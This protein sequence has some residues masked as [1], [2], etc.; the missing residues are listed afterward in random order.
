MF[1]IQQRMAGLSPA[2]AQSATAIAQALEA[3]RLDQAERDVTAARTAAPKHPEILRLFGLVEKLRGRPQQAIEALTQA[4]TLQP[5]DPFIQH[6]LAGAYEMVHDHARALA[7]MRRLCDLA[8]EMAASWFILG[9]FLFV[10]G[11]TEP[12]IRALQRAVELAPRHAYARTMLATVL[13]LDGRP[14]EAAAQ[15][16]A[17][18][19]SDTRC[20]P[21][22]WGLAT[23]KPMPLDDKDIVAMRKA[24]QSQM[25][26]HDR[27]ATGFALAHALEHRGDY[28]D[29][30]AALQQSNALAR[31]SEPWNVQQFEQRIENTLNVFPLP[32]SGGAASD[33]G[34]EVIFI[35]SLPRSGST[36]TEQIL[37]SH[38]QVTGT[39]ELTDLPQ[40]L[41]EEEARMRQALPAWAHAHSAEQW[42]TLGQRYLARTARWRRTR[43]RFTDKMPGNWLHI[44][45]IMA[46]L[47]AAR[48]IIVRRDPLET[49]FGCYR[50]LFNQH[51]YTHDFADLGAV[52][53]GFDRLCARWKELYPERVHVQVYEELIADPE[54]QIRELLRFCDLPF[55]QACLDFHATERRV[56]T[57][58]AGQVRQPI[59]RDT[60]RAA[61]YGALLDPL[62]S[63]LG[64]AP[65]EEDAE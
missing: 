21:A 12:A 2:L 27:V 1:T 25:T 63:A 14:Q 23:L 13:N 58:S 3:G 37:A 41:K 50:Y 43:Q 19:A 54:T 29:A 24:L 20:G 59:R 55:E 64:L 62:R 44:G 36:L 9:R 18:L 30:F 11:H 46:M 15:H 6:A 33:Q 40:V 22:W 65:F 45:A 32:P 4:A 47:P 8:P 49:C 28:A 53:H 17:I 34:K 61:K 56:T 42:L 16:R 35:V 51:G 10:N 5:Q 57:P 48:V 52:W 26:A 38:S 39:T 7:T 60:A 31:S